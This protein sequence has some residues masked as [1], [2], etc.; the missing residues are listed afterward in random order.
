MAADGFYGARLRQRAEE[1]GVQV[2]FAGVCW[3]FYRSMLCSRILNKNIEYSSDSLSVTPKQT[4][5]LN[6]FC[7]GEEYLPRSQQL[8]QAYGHIAR[9]IDSSNVFSS[10]CLPYDVGSLYL[11]LRRS[12][13]RHDVFLAALKKFH[14][15]SPNLDS[16]LDFCCDLVNCLQWSR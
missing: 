5:T 13:W 10:H 9:V 2:P 8:G 4:Q 16:T 15:T 11:D 1:L 6:R 12:G 7:S 14:Y 3:F